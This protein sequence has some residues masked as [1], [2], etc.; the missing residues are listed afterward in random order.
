MRTRAYIV[1]GTNTTSSAERL[2]FLNM[3]LGQADSGIRRGTKFVSLCTCLITQLLCPGIIQG[4]Q[5]LYNG[6]YSDA[7]VAVVST[8]SHAGVGG[9]QDI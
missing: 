6:T 3:D 8:H 1:A 2:L 9:A 5:K 7:N 4:L